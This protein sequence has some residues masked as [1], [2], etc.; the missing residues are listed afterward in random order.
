MQLFYQLAGITSDI[1][2]VRSFMF[3]VEYPW[4]IYCGGLISLVLNTGYICQ[5][6][7]HTFLCFGAIWRNPLHVGWVQHYLV[8]NLTWSI[9]PAPDSQVHKCISSILSSCCVLVWQYKYMYVVTKISQFAG[10]RNTTGRYMIPTFPHSILLLPCSDALLMLLFSP[11]L[12]H[13]LSPK[14]ID[15][16]CWVG[17]QES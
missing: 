12:I 14:M 7:E 9:S 8:T 4:D 3:W 2:V 16:F 10:M 11:K 17:F 1:D 6:W 15:L 5:C 13:V